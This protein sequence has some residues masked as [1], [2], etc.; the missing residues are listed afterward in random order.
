MKHFITIALLCFLFC[1]AENIAAKASNYSIT[2]PDGKTVVQIVFDNNL[3]YSVTHNGKEVLA[4]SSISMTINGILLPGKSNVKSAKKSSVND[5]I[6]SP[7]YKSSFIKENYNQ[8]DIKF[9]N[10]F[11]VI[12]RAYNEGTAYRFY[13]T[14]LKQGDKVTAEGAEYNFSKDYL[15]YIPYSRK[16][17]PFQTSFESRYDVAELSKMKG[18]EIA[19]S[20]ILVC[21][22][23]GMKVA[24]SESDIEAYPGMFLTKNEEKPSTNGN[25]SIKGIFANIPSEISV[26]PTRCQEKVVSYSDVMANISSTA[27]AKE[28]RLFPWRLLAIS[29]KDTELPTNNLPYLL[30]SKCRLTDVSWIKPG[31]V[32]WDWW[33]N[34][35]VT[36]VD[37]PVGINTQTYKYFIDFASANGI[38]YVVLDEGWSSP[39]GGDIMSVIPAID[40]KELVSYGKQKNVD[41]ILWCVAFTLDKKLEEACKHYSEMG[42]KGFKV[43]FMDRDDQEV[44]IMNYR[45]AEMAAKYKMLIDFHGM[46]KPAGLNRTYPNVINF[47]GV[48]GLE[49]MKWSTDDMMTYDVTFPFIRMLSGPVDYT[50]GAMRNSIKRD[51]VANNNN[52]FSQGTRA[53]QVAT[54][55]V[56]DS[57]LVMLCDNPTIYMK[58]QE[59]TDYIV[60]IPTV[61][62]ETRILAGEVGQYIVTA[63]RSGEKWYVGGLTGWEGR[64]LTINLDFLTSD[65]PH[66]ASLFRDGVNANRSA[67]DYKIEQII[68]TSDKSLTIKLANGGGFALIIE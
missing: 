41:L 27:S 55:V 50:Q 21:L 43:D 28:P 56:F 38:E 23:S 9:K 11:G 49:Q 42:I 18:G 36:G 53:H 2:S 7:I 34:W 51:F 10:G 47:E 39:K 1:N 12:F 22:D 67:T 16:A 54:Y 52:P 35:G 63:R 30:G 25:Y 59:T 19:F 4:P 5:I 26:H 29:E 60:S 46:Y 40:L 24:I 33:N 48:W 3:S 17:N 62:E 14:T 32:A 68:V 15:T 20:P 31:K 8:I 44:V 6:D 57:P 13:S 65:K 61:W 37:F 58:E 66:K 64:E 45:I